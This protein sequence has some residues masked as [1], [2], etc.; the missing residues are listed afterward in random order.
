MRNWSHESLAFRGR[1]LTYLERLARE[2]NLPLGT[3]EE[4]AHGKAMPVTSCI[5]AA[6]SSSRFQ[7][8]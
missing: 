3:L 6:P 5:A 2:N 8:V 1:P 4:F 7:G